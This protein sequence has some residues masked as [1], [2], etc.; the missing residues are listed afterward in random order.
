[1]TTEIARSHEMRSLWWAL[2]HTMPSLV[3]GLP[4]TPLSRYTATSAS[5]TGNQKYKSHVAFAFGGQCFLLVV[6]VLKTQAPVLACHGKKSPT[7]C[8]AGSCS[9]VPY[10]RLNNKTHV[11][12]GKSVT[13]ETEQKFSLYRLTNTCRLT[14]SDLW[15]GHNFFLTP[16]HWFVI[17]WELTGGS[18]GKKLR[19]FIPVKST[20][21][22]NRRQTAALPLLSLQCSV[23]LCNVNI[24]V[25]F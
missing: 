2:S 18:S 3:R 9:L 17:K 19:W 5:C 4:K 12:Q 11:M 21:G 10:L 8:P 20:R 25:I 1:M 13:E 15:A 23:S 6:A 22:Q 24:T 16:L 14:E 7:I